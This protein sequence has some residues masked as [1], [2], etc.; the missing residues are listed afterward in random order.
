MQKP[1]IFIMMIFGATIF[2]PAMLTK[3]I[4]GV[5]WLQLLIAFVIYWWLL[6][7]VL[8]GGEFNDEV[9]GFSVLFAGLTSWI[10]VTIAGALLRFTGLPGRFL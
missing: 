8:G 10:G 5:S 7:A 9:I 2:V 6:V 1:L 4:I 3:F